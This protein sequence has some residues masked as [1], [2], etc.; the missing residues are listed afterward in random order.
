MKSAGQEREM[1]QSNGEQRGFI[2]AM[3]SC[4]ARVF[5]LAIIAAAPWLFLYSDAARVA[6][7]QPAFQ[8]ARTFPSVAES[9]RI[10]D[11]RS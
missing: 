4:V 7:E 11:G 6:A 8:V 3:L 10:F 9:K 2:A 5:G 1:S